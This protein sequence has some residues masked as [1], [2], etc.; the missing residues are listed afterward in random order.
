M[1]RSSKRRCRPIILELQLILRKQLQHGRQNSMLGNHES[2]GGR[3]E[4]SC[5]GIGKHQWAYHLVQAYFSLIL[6]YEESSG[7][8]HYDPSNECKGAW[9]GATWNSK[10]IT[11]DQGLDSV[12]EQAPWLHWGT[13][14]VSPPVSIARFECKGPIPCGF[15]ISRC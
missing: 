13:H 10:G 2:S 6:D 1:L 8:S 5:P 12:T 7:Q 4:G 9:S 15:L 14:F 3:L 11:I